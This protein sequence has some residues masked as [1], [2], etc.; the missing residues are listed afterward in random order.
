MEDPFYYDLV[1]CPIGIV[2]P[3]HLVVNKAWNEVNDYLSGVGLPTLYYADKHYIQNRY[4]KEMYETAKIS[5][6]L[7]RE[8][9]PGY[10][11]LRESSKI[12][13]DALCKVYPTESKLLR[14]YSDII[15]RYPCKYAYN[16]HIEKVVRSLNLGG[17]SNE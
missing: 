17:D 3:Y 16:S 2:H 12:V 10:T 4:G 11:M 6:N 7:D 8:I 14:F 9:N 15:L 13:S 1:L 5:L